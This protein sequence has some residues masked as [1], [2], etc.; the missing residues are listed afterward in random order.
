MK[1][2]APPG[3]GFPGWALQLQRRS[4]GGGCEA[5]GLLIPWLDFTAPEE[6]GGL[7]FKPHG[8]EAPLRSMR[9]LSSLSELYGAVQFLFLTAEGY[10]VWDLV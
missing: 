4:R 3:A 1:T 7:L 10:I 6:K 2:A 9:R 8:R 5:T